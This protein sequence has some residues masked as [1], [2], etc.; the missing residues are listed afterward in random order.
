MYFSDPS[1]YFPLFYVIAQVFSLLG[2]TC[3]GNFPEPCDSNLPT[4]LTSCPTYFSKSWILD[5]VSYWNCIIFCWIDN[6]L[7][8]SD[9]IISFISSI[10]VPLLGWFTWDGDNLGWYWICY[11]LT[12]WFCDVKITF[13]ILISQGRK[14]PPSRIVSIRIRV[15]V[16]L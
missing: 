14:I 13:L 5:L 8:A 9:F 1:N 2:I 7:D 12:P 11:W 10:D 15:I 3:D 4:T 16:V 6:I